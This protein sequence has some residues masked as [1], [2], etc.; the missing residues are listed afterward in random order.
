V[1]LTFDDGYR[2]VYTLAWPLLKR[3]RLP[4][5]LF[6]AV[7]AIARG[8]LWPDVLRHTIQRTRETSVAL[9][10]LG[11]SGP[12]TFE[13]ASDSQRLRAVRHLDARLKPLRP[14]ERERVLGELVGK[15][16]R[17]ASEGLMVERVMLSWE[18]LAA[19]TA[20]G[21]EIG[22]HTV[23]HSILTRLSELEARDEILRSRQ[24]LEER[25]RVPIRHFSYPN[26]QASD[27]SPSIERLIE[28]AR[29]RS[30]CTAIRGVNGP[31]ENRFE[32]KRIDGAQA[33]VKALAGLG[34]DR[35]E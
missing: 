20:D 29:F 21:V 30:A 17:V 9:E 22:A 2:D 16:L 5:T 35:R 7:G 8:S 28:A 31:S 12:S 33:L 1:A 3:Y 27:F 32:L 10:T 13:L 11:D 6:V 14:D 15:L 4:A 19:L 34:K 23:S 18:E 26:G 24:M 25:L